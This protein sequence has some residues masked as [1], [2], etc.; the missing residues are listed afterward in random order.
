MKLRHLLLL[1]IP[2][3]AFG[4]AQPV[5]AA[6]KGAHSHGEDESPL[7]EAMKTMGRALRKLNR[8]I[9]DPA[10]IDSSKE[11]LARMKAAT[12]TAKGLEPSPENAWTDAE[13]A[14]FRKRLEAVIVTI[15]KAEQAL[16][17]GEF[18]VAKERVADLTREKKAGHEEFDVGDD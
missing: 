1:L 5:C 18:D 12:E 15:D 10:L 11:L 4:F 14:D 17:E 3:A 7:H 13:K 6:D 9:D 16:A 8:Q 2:L